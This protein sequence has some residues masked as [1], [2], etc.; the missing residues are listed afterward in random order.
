MTIKGSPVLWGDD[1]IE[2]I[3]EAE[4]MGKKETPV[5]NEEQKKKIERMLKF[6]RL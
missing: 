1:A 5:L 6:S 4:S 3:N 2:F